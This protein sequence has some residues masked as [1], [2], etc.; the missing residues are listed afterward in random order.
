LFEYYNMS[1]ADMLIRT[2]CWRAGPIKSANKGKRKTERE[3]QRKRE[4]KIEGAP[5]GR[6]V[7]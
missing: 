3:K 7:W 2:S 5:E 1:D 4:R 6:E